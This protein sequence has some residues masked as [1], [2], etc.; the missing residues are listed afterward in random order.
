[1]FDKK[2]D[3]VTYFGRGPIENYPDRKTAFDVGL[4]DLDVNNQY[5]YEKPMERGNHEE[6]RWAD[7]NG[8]GMPSLLIQADKNLMQF[9]A[10]PHTDE[11]MF[12][13]EYKIDLP[14]SAATVFC[15][16]TK[17]LGVGSNSCGPRPVDKYLIW[18]D[19]TRFAY[20][21]QLK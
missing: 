19:N 17:T 5:T 10:L 11:Q 12:P 6:V 8:N 13:V 20:T 7:L 18:T 14:P 15:L 21:L 1:M 4:Y 9:S 3:H 16:S 2:L